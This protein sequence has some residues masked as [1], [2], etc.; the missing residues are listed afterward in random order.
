MR[1]MYLVGGSGPEDFPW[2]LGVASATSAAEVLRRK[3]GPSKGGVAHELLKRGI[4][5]SIFRQASSEA[6]LLSGSEVSTSHSSIRGGLGCRPATFT[7]DGFDYV[8]YEHYCAVFLHRYRHARAALTQGGILWRLAV[9][10]LDEDVILDGPTEESLHQRWVVMDNAPYVEDFLT[11]S[12]KDLICGMY[13][14]FNGMC[15][16]AP[17]STINLPFV[18]G[19]GSSF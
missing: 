7:A 17:N 12:R 5:F 19:S 9:Q 4:P 8:L 16:S 15:C 1:H 6:P 14:L 3:W 11:A 18:G 13:K 2:M 10:Y